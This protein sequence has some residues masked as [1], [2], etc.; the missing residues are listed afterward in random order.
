[1]ARKNPPLIYDGA[2]NP[3]ACSA[4]CQSLVKRFGP[5]RVDFIFGAMG[6]KD[7]AKMIRNLIPAAR[8]FTF[9]SPS[10]PRAVDP[11]VF[12]QTL[13]GSRIPRKAVRT[14]EDIVQLINSASADS[15]TCVSG[16]FYTVGDIRSAM[17]GSQVSDRA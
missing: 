17:S 15:V 13:K 5:R 7:Y 9:F 10:V 1:M 6:D 4:L 2:H 11:D 3:K 16:S 12:A 8:S 14:L